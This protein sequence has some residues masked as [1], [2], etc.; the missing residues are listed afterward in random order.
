MGFVNERI[1]Q[2][3]REKYGLDE[4]DAWI[5]KTARVRNRD[6]TIDHEREIYLREIDR[7]REESSHKTTWH[8]Y[9]KGELMMVC[10]ELLATGGERGGHGWSRYRLVD[11]YLEGS[12]IPKKMQQMREEIVADLKAALVAYGDGGIYSTTTSHETTLVT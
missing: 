11:C 8:F 5:K 6:W 2:E 12:F 9:W 7:G 1:S 3:D 4:V 10:L